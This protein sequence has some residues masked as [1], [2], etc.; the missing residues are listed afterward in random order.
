MEIK[1]KN[2]PMLLNFWKRIWWKIGF[3]IEDYTLWNFIWL[4]VY[5]IQKLWNKLISLF[6]NFDNYKVWFNM[7][8]KSRN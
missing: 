7:T 2:M 6:E 3:K 1:N 5:A 8:M 4:F